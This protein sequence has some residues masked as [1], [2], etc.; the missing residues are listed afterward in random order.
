MHK[1]G[2]CT[3]V[4]QGQDKQCWCCHQKSIFFVQFKHP[5][6]LAGMVQKVVYTPGRLPLYHSANTEKQINIHAHIHTYSHFR[7]ANYPK[8][9]MSLGCGRKSENN[10]RGPTTVQ[11]GYNIIPNKGPSHL[12]P[13]Y[14][15]TVMTAASVSKMQ[16]KMYL[17]K[18]STRN[19]FYFS[20]ILIVIPNIF[21][22]KF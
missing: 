18:R 20:C 10:Q 11:G 2:F 5:S 16:Y 19:M 4:Q 17:L 13:C 8:L 6:I 15:A 21:K 9:C 22:L 3:V 12:D 1:T 7:I 14:D